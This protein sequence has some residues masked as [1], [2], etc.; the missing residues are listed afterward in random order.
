MA[1]PTPQEM[2]EAIDNAI[3]TILSGG[4]VQEYAIEGRSL[5]RY[6]LAELRDMRKQYV[7][8]IQA[9]GGNRTKVQFEE[10]A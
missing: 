7:G 3:S 8:E 9:V 6:S 2:V 1:S 5:S 4:V 10:P